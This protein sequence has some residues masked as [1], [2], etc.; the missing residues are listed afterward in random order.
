MYKHRPPESSLGYHF[1]GVIEDVDLVSHNQIVL[2]FRRSFPG[3][4]E[5]ISAPGCQQTRD[6]A[7]AID[8]PGFT[9][10]LPGQV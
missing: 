2:I 4:A 10:R 1:G 6:I 5:I 7:D 9:G 8:P 3:H